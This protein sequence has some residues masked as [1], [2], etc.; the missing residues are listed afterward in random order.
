MEQLTKLLQNLDCTEILLVSFGR[1]QQKIREG[2]TDFDL[3]PR[4]KATNGKKSRNW[5]NVLEE[6]KKIPVNKRST[7]RSLSFATN[8]PVS[9]LHYL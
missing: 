8:I 1:K 5:S 4:K 6:M 7:F 3:S 9:I 2:R